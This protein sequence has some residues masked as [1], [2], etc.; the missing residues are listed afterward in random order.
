[1]SFPQVAEVL[2]GLVFVYYVL[3]AVV[4]TITQIIN[5]SLETR[6]LALEKYL[7]QIAGDKLI[8][9]TSLPQIQAL[10][11]IRYANWWNVFGSGTEPKRVEKI[12]ASTLVDAFFDISGLSCKAEF[13]ADEL[14]TTLN[15]LPDSDGKRAMIQWVQQGITDMKDLRGHAS[16]YFT[17][18]L[19]QAASTFKARARSLVIILSLVVT[20][21]LGTDSI[22]LAR[23]LWSDSALR[24]LASAQASMAAAQP[25]AQGNVLQ[26]NDLVSSLGSYSLRLGWWQAQTLPAAGSSAIEWVTFAVLKLLGLAIT[27]LAV[28]QGSSFWYDLLRRLTGQKSP[29]L[30]DAPDAGAAS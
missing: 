4:S 5:E 10:R 6:G 7:R 15:Q 23:D 18:L 24:A 1:M 30:A 26:I 19:T 27:A 28:S 16:D 25:T 11:P 14:I 21:L 29:P 20:L 13:T 3:G 2:I 9:L 12:P 22:Q 17:G 8:D